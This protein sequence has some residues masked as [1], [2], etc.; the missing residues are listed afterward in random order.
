MKKSQFIL[1][2][3]FLA[4]IGY[5]GWSY[6]EFSAGTLGKTEYFG[7]SLI[8]LFVLVALLVIFRSYRLWRERRELL[9]DG[10]RGSLRS[11]LINIA[12]GLL[13]EAQNQEVIKL[14]GAAGEAHKTGKEALRVLRKH[15]RAVYDLLPPDKRPAK[16]KADKMSAAELETFLS[17][18][19]A[20]L[21]AIPPAPKPEVKVTPKPEVRREPPPAPAPDPTIPLRQRIE[22]LLG[23]NSSLTG[24][25]ATAKAEAGRRDREL[26][27]LRDQLRVAQASL[28][29]VRCR[30]VPLQASGPS[31]TETAAVER[32]NR[33]E[34]AAAET[35]RETAGRIAELEAAATRTKEGLEGRIAELECLLE[36]CRADLRESQAALGAAQELHRTEVSAITQR[37]AHAKAGRSEAQSKLEEAG[38][39]LADLTREI[40]ELR[41][42]IESERQ[43]AASALGLYEETLGLLRAAEG[44]EQA[45]LERE[46]SAAEREGAAAERESN[47]GSRLTALQTRFDALPSFVLLQD[48]VK[49]A[50]GSADALAAWVGGLGDE[51]EKRQQALRALLTSDG[52]ATRIAELLDELSERADAVAEDEE[53]FEEA[54]EPVDT[55]LNFVFEGVDSLALSFLE[56]LEDERKGG[57]SSSMGHALASTLFGF[58]LSSPERWKRLRKS[59]ERCRK[60]MN[61][62]P[63]ALRMGLAEL[64]GDREDFLIFTLATSRLAHAT[65]KA[66]MLCNLSDDAL[67]THHGVRGSVDRG[68]SLIQDPHGLRRLRWIIRTSSTHRELFKAA[69]D[70]LSALYQLSPAR[71]KSL[72]TLLLRADEPGALM[73]RAE[74]EELIGFDPRDIWAFLDTRPE[75]LQRYRVLDTLEPFATIAELSAARGKLTELTPLEELLEA[76]IFSEESGRPRHIEDV[77]GL[78]RRREALLN[79]GNQLVQASLS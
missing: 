8:V 22:E 57:W 24:E 78:T 6:F 50:L 46:R 63:P 25:L 41:G 14:R 17:E 5:L 48:E 75:T 1:L 21:Q 52:A 56:I 30:S 35:Q 53:K 7:R 65:Y 54:N 28:E 61:V 64:A 38:R 40:E 20:A 58:S 27:E 45:G 71:W 59:S 2:G 73:S 32:A 60:I 36:A 37:E 33:L 68:R 76:Y 55:I 67:R 26:A 51:P 34:A 12:R 69:S 77:K 4:A 49:A 70:E 47:L 10:E 66:R 15:A 44:R 43:K 18:S 23:A 39:Q 16:F 3:L 13:K 72:V 74:I 19:A 29:E 62:M 9:A 31:E 42:A 79:R 11:L